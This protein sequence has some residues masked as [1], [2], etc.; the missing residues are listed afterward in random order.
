MLLLSP[1]W[2]L[3]LCVPS[4][5]LLF[6]WIVNSLCPSF[7]LSGLLSFS[8]FAIIALRHL[9]PAAQ[10]RPGLIFCHSRSL[11]LHGAL[12]ASDAFISFPNTPHPCYSSVPFSPT[13]SAWIFFFF[14]LSACHLLSLGPKGHF[15]VF[16]HVI[17]SQFS[18]YY[19]SVISHDFP[20]RKGAPSI[21][22]DF[23]T[24]KSFSHLYISGF[25]YV[26]SY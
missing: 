20:T 11:S 25:K 23:P 10:H 24:R 12:L 6:L 17:A 7:L 8:S 18:L 4:M 14:T 5:F 26:P 2:C 22:H 16:Q 9:D 1:H 13:S 15:P 3:W 19:Y 21:S